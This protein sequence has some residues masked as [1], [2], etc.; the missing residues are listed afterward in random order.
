MKYD[1][2]ET[3]VWYS[4]IALQLQA[5]FNGHYGCSAGYKTIQI[6][7]SAFKVITTDRIAMFRCV[8]CPETLYNSVGASR[9]SG[10]WSVQYWHIQAP[11]G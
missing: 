7:C 8:L 3:G 10:I 11:K 9:Y 1:H 6:V 5:G 2:N 4:D